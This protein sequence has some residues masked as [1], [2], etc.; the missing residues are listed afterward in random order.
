[1][2]KMMMTMMLMIMTYLNVLRTEISLSDES[3]IFQTASLTELKR[4]ACKKN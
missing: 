1:M 4:L 2:I 3:N